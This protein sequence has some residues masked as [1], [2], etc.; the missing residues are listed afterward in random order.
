MNL[1]VVGARVATRMLDDKALPQRE[2][3]IV[4][5]NIA[6]S[7]YAVKLHLRKS[8]T[9]NNVLTKIVFPTVRA[10]ESERTQKRREC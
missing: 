8:A 2:A 9:D 5:R 1:E 4:S 7:Q 6:D 3:T 10:T